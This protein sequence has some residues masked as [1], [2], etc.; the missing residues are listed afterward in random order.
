M[1]M[2]CTERVCQ[3]I[4]IPGTLVQGAAVGIH[5][6]AVIEKVSKTL[7]QHGSFRFRESLAWKLLR[8]IYLFMAPRQFYHQDQL[9]RG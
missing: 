8:R 9:T 2:I 7:N 5:R 1:W 4:D 3:S 6:V